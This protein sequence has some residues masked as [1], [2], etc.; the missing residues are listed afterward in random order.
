M[1]KLI[2]ILVLVLLLLSFKSPFAESVSDIL[3]YNESS[4]DLKFKE[5]VKLIT[6]PNK[7]IKLKIIGCFS[8]LGENFFY[9]KI[10]PF[11]KIKEFNS[12]LV[13]KDS[14]SFSDLLNEV[15]NNGFSNYTSSLD[16]NF[17][18]ITLQELAVLGLF[19]GYRYISVF[20]KNKDEYGKI[21]LSYSPPM[22]KHNIS[23]Y[24]SPKEYSNNLLEPDTPSSS[25][26]FKCNSGDY[27]CGS[28][29]YPNIKNTPH[30]AVYEII[31]A[32]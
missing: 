4:S 8:N 18:N 30:F 6:D 14:S 15:N 7:D 12:L 28:A 11:A 17:N 3:S 19:A 22:N 27:M 5:H 21:F 32:V 16:K 9:K 31:E 13:I 2:I 26:G 23:G 10:N 24:F 29:N 1:I 25:C 20:K